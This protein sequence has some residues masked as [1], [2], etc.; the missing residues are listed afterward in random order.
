MPDTLGLLMPLVVESIG[1]IKSRG[2][3]VVVPKEMGRPKPPQIDVDVGRV[4]LPPKPELTTMLLPIAAAVT[5]TSP[6]MF[7]TSALT[8]V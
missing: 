3:C 5:A 4:Y 8:V 2:A 1:K 6:P 7:E